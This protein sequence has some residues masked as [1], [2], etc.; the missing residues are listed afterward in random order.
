MGFVSPQN[1]SPPPSRPA[2]LVQRPVKAT[3][4]LEFRQM[5]FLGS[6]AGREAKLLADD[7]ADVGPGHVTE[8]GDELLETSG[9]EEGIVIISTN[10]PRLGFDKVI[11]LDIQNF[12]DI[13]LYDIGRCSR[14]LVLKN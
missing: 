1:T 4:L 6:N 13:Q 3:L 12:Q 14:A 8:L 9:G 2:Q 7:A 10:R 11:F 5:W